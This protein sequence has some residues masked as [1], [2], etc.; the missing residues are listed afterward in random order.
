[1][2]IRKRRRKIRGERGGE[3]S[4]GVY[5]YICEETEEKKNEK[6]ISIDCVP[7]FSAFMSAFTESDADKKEE[8]P[9]I[10]K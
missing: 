2:R 8:K 4:I 6:N 10:T 5:A 3:K 7:Y 9:C 1:M